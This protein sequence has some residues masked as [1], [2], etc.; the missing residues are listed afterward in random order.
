MKKGMKTF[1]R[2]MTLFAICTLLSACNSQDYTYPDASWKDGIIVNVGGKDYTYKQIYTL[3]DGKKDAAKADYSTAKNILAQLVTPRTDAILLTVDGAMKQQEETWKSAAKTNNTSYKE[4][5]EKTLKSEG[6]DDEE[7]LRNK[8]IAAE[9]NTQNSNAFYAEQDGTTDKDSKFYISEEET[10]TFVTNT[11]PYHVSHILVKVDA[12]ATGEGTWKGEISSDDAKQLGNVIGAL[13]STNTFGT[14][15][16]TQSDDTGSAALYGEL[17]GS[18]QIGMLKST[19]YIQEFKYGVYAYDAYLNPNTKANADLK[20]SLR[21][22][23]YSDDKAVAAEIGDTE[24]GKGKSY[25]IPLSVAF[26]IKYEAEQQKSDSGITVKDATADQYPRNILFNN[27]F[28]NHAVSF[29][30]DDSADYDATFLA[31]AKL[32]D[33]SITSLADV[34]T[35]L[36]ERYKEYESVKTSLSGINADR[37]ATVTGVSDNLLTLT[38]DPTLTTINPISGTKKILTDENGNPVITVRGGTSGDSGY[39]GIHFIVVNKDPFVDAENVYNYYRV[40]V[41][42][43]TQT[44]TA[45]TTDYKTNPSFVN[46]VKGDANSTTTYKSRVQE[47]K[48]VIK[49][50]DSNMDFKLWEANLAKFKT[51]YGE[52]FETLLGTDVADAINNYISYTRESTDTTANDSLDTAWEGYVRTISLQETN[53]N[54]VIPTVCVSYFQTGSYTDEQEVLC[55]VK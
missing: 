21:V 15:A 17:S 22:P 12:A 10:K 54:R 31:N 27:Y 52:D 39:Q 48:D 37:F 49:A 25:G 47:V 40:N 6:C 4:E 23:G 53:I 44:A 34:Q 55:H 20:T 33:S 38:S 5:M 24:F 43:S 42:D 9:Q 50:S 32:F 28:N 19:S 46:F 7:A 2:A 3:M 13:S 8:K 14:V 45:Y 18:A 11:A 26:T 51:K 29:I 35:K 16:K 41:P 30:Y 1:T 36:P